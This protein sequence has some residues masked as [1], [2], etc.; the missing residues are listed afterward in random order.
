MVKKLFLDTFLR[1]RC[2][3]VSLLSFNKL[4]L[5]KGEPDESIRHSLFSF[6]KL[7]L[8]TIVLLELCRFRKNLFI[9]SWVLEWR[10]SNNSNLQEYFKSGIIKL[11]DV[12]ISLVT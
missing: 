2:H 6:M 9:A 1:T 5:G 7:C 3:L 8:K 10:D 11:S 4:Y 12:F